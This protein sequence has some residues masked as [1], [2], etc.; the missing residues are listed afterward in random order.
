MAEATRAPARASRR[1]S[2]RVRLIGGLLILLFLALFSLAVVVFV[3]ERLGLPSEYLYVT[4]VAAIGVDLVLLGLVADY[5]LRILVAK[6]VARMVEGAEKIAAGV[7]EHR[8]PPSDTAEIDRL[9]TAVNEM[10]D[11]LIHNQQVLAENV[12]SLDETNREL[13]AVRSNLARADKMASIGRLASGIAHEIGNPLGAIMGY[14]ELG[15]R[16][17][18]GESEWLGGISHEAGRID[19]IV[20]GLLDYGRPKAAAIREVNVNG[21]IEQA[22]DLLRAQGKLK[23]VDLSVELS[24]TRPHVTADPFQLEQVLVNLLLNANDAIENSPEERWIRV[25]AGTTTI[26]AGDRWGTARN[27]RNDPQ[28]LDYS[29]LRRL[30]QARDPG[31]AP[32]FSE[33]ESAVEVVVV[34]SGPGIP[35]QDVQRVFEPFFTTKD[36]GLGTGLGLAVS[37]RLI[38]VMGGTIEAVA[39]GEAGTTFRIL[40]PVAEERA[41]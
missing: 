37:A 19:A 13:S 41:E 22:V 7:E 20:R 21:V 27:R 34:D 30:D 33:G 4:L 23:D 31:P 14:V 8:L 16:R 29:H 12:R 11:R 32:Q 26:T 24:A 2:L 25:R 17:G 3:W 6:P 10:A 35:A 36:P 39:G 18:E 15:R 28:G 1:L 40:L 5:R 38:E 9:S